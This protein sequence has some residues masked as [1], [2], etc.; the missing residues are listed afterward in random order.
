MVRYNIIESQFKAIQM[1]NTIILTALFVSMLPALMV[2]SAQAFEVEQSS[3][4]SKLDCRDV[5]LL[6][7]ATKEQR[8]LTVLKTSTGEEPFFLSEHYCFAYLR[9][10]TGDDT[11]QNA[12]HTVD[13]VVNIVRNYRAVFGQLR[14]EEQKLAFIHLYVQTL[15]QRAIVYPDVHGDLANISISTSTNSD[16][17]RS[18]GF[19]H[20]LIKKEDNHRLMLDKLADI[21][22]NPPTAKDNPTIMAL[23]LQVLD[24]NKRLSAE[25]VQ[26]QLMGY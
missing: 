2:G 17:F 6:R 13:E 9:A 25:S 23:V 14:S 1:K 21:Q 4:K 24:V 8:K 19:F 12:T 26:D 22:S 7:D 18:G 15:S 10:F 16:K 20:N 11:S 5:K 3:A